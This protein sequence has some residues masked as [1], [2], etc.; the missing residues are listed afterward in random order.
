MKKLNTR[1]ILPKILAVIALMASANFSFAHN[2]T[3]KG[4]VFDADSKIGLPGAN[5][6]INT[7]PAQATYTD[8]LGIFSFSDLPSGEFSV[9]ISYIGFGDTTI[10]VRVKDHETS[11]LK[12]SLSPQEINLPDVSITSEANANLQTISALDIQTRPVN[13][14]QDILRIVPGAG[15]CAARWRWQGRADFP[16][17]LRH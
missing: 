13:T 8:E 14:S 10:M 15:H 12:I 2:G 7:D 16:A 1:F 3:I 6:R 5:I 11:T 4:M 9:S 17:G